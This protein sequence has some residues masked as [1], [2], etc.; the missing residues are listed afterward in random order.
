MKALIT[1]LAFLIIYIAG[2]ITGN[3]LARVGL[4][5]EVIELNKAFYGLNNK[6]ESYENA[7]KNTL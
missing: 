6:G 1:A 4:E 7:D 5:R 3:F 2:I